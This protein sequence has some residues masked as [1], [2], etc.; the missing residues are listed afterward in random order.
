MAKNHVW[1]AQRPKGEPT[2][3]LLI[4][5]RVKLPSKYISLYSQINVALGPQRRRTLFNRGWLMLKFTACPRVEDKFLQSVQLHKGH[6]YH[7]PFRGEG[8]GTSWRR[9][10]KTVTAGGQEDWSGPAPSGHDS[11]TSSSCGRL[12]DIYVR[13]RQSTFQHGWKGAWEPHP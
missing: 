4:G 7:S 9:S 6:F 3:I 12:H 11:W 2:T 10:R 13:L 5:H 1:G 8:Q